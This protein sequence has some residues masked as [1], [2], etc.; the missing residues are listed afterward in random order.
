MANY[1]HVSKLLVAVVMLMTTTTIDARHHHPMCL[2]DLDIQ[3]LVELNVTEMKDMIVIKSPVT[4]EVA[5]T[6]AQQYH[7]FQ[8][9][10]LF[11]RTQVNKL[12]E[13]QVTFVFPVSGNISVQSFVTA[14]NENNENCIGLESIDIIVHRQDGTYDIV[15]DDEDADREANDRANEIPKRHDD[16]DNDDDDDGD[17]DYIIHNHKAHPVLLFLFGLSMGVCV[18]FIIYFTLD[19]LRVQN[20]THEMVSIQMHENILRHGQSQSYLQQQPQEETSTSNWTSPSFDRESNA[21]LGFARKFVPKN[22]RTTYF[23]I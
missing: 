7:N 15:P 16:D 3:Y 11:N 12:N 23:D 17:D 13:P 19:Y 9:N 2:L 18:I 1:D 5:V 6:N 14:K 10:W 20:E 22:K 21:F 4:F 8:Y